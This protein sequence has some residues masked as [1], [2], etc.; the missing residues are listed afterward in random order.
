MIDE[1]F[2]FM[3]CEICMILCVALGCK[4]C[5]S[6]VSILE[7]LERKEGEEKKVQFYFLSS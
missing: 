5:T 2:S 3:Y 4:P 6:N 1:F 7:T